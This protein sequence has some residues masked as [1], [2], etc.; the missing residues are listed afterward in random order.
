MFTPNGTR[1]PSNPPL[2]DRQCPVELPELP[3]WPV[4]LWSEYEKEKDNNKGFKRLGPEPYRP[5]AEWTDLPP[6]RLGGGTRSRQG[7]HEGDKVCGRGTSSRHCGDGDF[8]E[9]GRGI[10][11]R[12]GLPHQ[13]SEVRTPA[14]VRELWLQREVEQLQQA[15]EREKKKSGSSWGAY[16]DQPVHRYA[17]DPDLERAKHE[18]QEGDRVQH[19]HHGGCGH[20]RAS[21]HAGD[22]GGDRAQQWHQGDAG[23]RAGDGGG[24]GGA[25]RHQDLPELQVGDLSLLVLGDWMEMIALIMKDVSPQ[26]HR[27]WPLV[28]MEAKQYYEQ[29]RE[30]TPMAR[31]DINPVCRVVEEDPSLHR[32]EQRGISLLIKAIPSNIKDTIISERL[33]TSTGIVFT[34]LKN[35]QPGGIGER[36]T[37]LKALT[38]PSYGK[39]LGEVA[40]TLRSWR[41][42]YR[43]TE[44]IEAILPD[45]SVLLKSLEAPCQLVSKVDAQATFR[46]SQARVAL[47][48]DAKPNNK[49][50]WNFSECLLAELDS[51]V[52][53]QGGDN[54]SSTPPTPAVKAITTRPGGTGACKFWGSQGGCKLGK[55]CSFAHNWQDLED[56]TSR[57]FLCSAT[58]HRKQECPTRQQGDGALAGGSGNG[59]GSGPGSGRGNYSKSKGKGK[60]N[61][62]Q[63]QDGLTT[64]PSV[65]QNSGHSS[66]SKDLQ[67]EGPSASVKAMQGST[68]SSASSVAGSTLSSTPDGANEKELLGEVTNL[69]KSLRVN[70]G[71]AQSPQQSPQLSAIRLARVLR[72][73]KSVLIDGGA[74]HCL[75]NPHSREECLNHAEEVRV[76]LAAG[77]VRMRQDTGTGTLYSED[78]DIQPIIPLADVIKIGVV[79]K[80]DSSGCEMRFRSGEKLP[81]CL[82]DGYPMLPYGKGME[83]LYEVEEFNR[84]K[85]KLRMAVVNPQPDRDQEEAFMSRLARLFPEVPLRLL[86]RYWESSS[87]T[88]TSWGSTGGSEDKLT[89]QKRSS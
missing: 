74:I 27:W 46:L 68:G 88:T 48:V 58:G 24:L 21:Q 37:L 67:E 49:S 3:P 60:Q 86:E 47:E 32:T 1:V 82:Q 35:Y 10:D 79:V 34:L 87:M 7:A 42:F 43:R 51:L 28:E 39:S 70:E 52:L 63:Q 62:K 2:R 4:S 8:K 50:V 13:A 36:A 59:N 54:K 85:I 61:G 26:A 57:C 25:G 64:T 78:P 69:L 73:D 5:R 45:P 22:L 18:L 89:G 65:P 76:D 81:V 23:E 31:L 72:S 16:W 15:L 83:L 40:S 71:V 41:R 80:W 66:P 53:M 55:R 84:R 77:A 17:R 29:W 14:E 9:P 44:E 38:A 19:L 30:A 33:M 56:R 75:R 12:Q 6:E 11:S 20:S